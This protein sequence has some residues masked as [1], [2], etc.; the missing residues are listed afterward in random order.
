MKPKQLD[1]D[2]VEESSMNEVSSPGE[3]L[4]ILLEPE[5]LLDKVSSI[6]CPEKC[7]SSQDPHLL[8]R[9]EVLIRE[10]GPQNKYCKSHL[11]EA[12][13]SRRTLNAMSSD[14]E[15]PVVQR[16]L[17]TP[18]SI[19]LPV[20]QN[21]LS[22][23]QVSCDNLPGSLRKEV[24][25]SK[26]VSENITLEND[27]GS[28]KVLAD[29]FSAAVIGN[30]LQGNT[31]KTV[32]G[33]KV[34]SHPAALMD[35]FNVGLTNEVLCIGTLSESGELSRGKLTT[36]GK[37][38]SFPTEIQIME[39]FKESITSDVDGLCHQH[40]K[41]KT[42]SQPDKFLPPSSSSL[43]KPLESIKRSSQK[44]ILDGRDRSHETVL[45]FTSNELGGFPVLCL[46]DQG[47]SSPH[48]CLMEQK[49]VANPF[50]SGVDST[51]RGTI[52]N[53][54]HTSH[55][56]NISEHESSEHLDCVERST[57]RVRNDTR[58]NA[59]LLDDSSVPPGIYNSVLNG[60]DETVPEF[61]KFV[62]KSDDS[63]PSTAVDGIELE[64]FSL[65]SNTTEYPSILGDFRNSAFMNS[66]LCYS[67]TRYGLQKIPDL[68]Q[69]LPNGLLEG[70]DLRTSFSPNDERGRSLSDC[71]P[72]FR[73]QQSWDIKKPYASPVTLWDKITSNFGSSAK[74][75]SLKPELPCISEENENVDGMADTFQM[76]IGSE[77]IL[78]AIRRQPL[79]EITDNAKASAAVS[80][81]DILADGRG[82]ESIST[83]LSFSGTQIKAKKKL[84][85]QNGCKNRCTGTGKEIQSILR[86][87]NGPKRKTESSHNRS[88]RP[89]LSAKNSMQKRGPTYSGG[90]SIGN[91]IVSTIT[92][93]IPLVQQKQ[94]AAACTGK[95]DIKVKALETAVAAKRIA[96]KKENERKMKKEALRLERERLEQENLRQVEL[97]KKKKEEERKR[98][99]AEMAAKKR[100]R[101]E[102]ERKERERK[103]K[104][105]D[106]AKR[107]QK[108]H[109]E[110]KMCA[111]KE[112]RDMKSQAAVERA[113]ESKE[114]IDEREI[115]K[116]M[117][118]NMEGIRKN[119]QE[120][121]SMTVSNPTNDETK[122]SIIEDSE[123]VN[124]FENDRKVISN[125]T[126]AAQDDDLITKNT[127]E[128]QS[129]EI[130]PY[131]GSDDEDEDEDD[132]PSNKFI[133]SWASKHRL[134]RMVSSQQTV[135]PETVFPRQS[136]CSIAEVLLPR[137][138]QLN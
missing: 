137:R 29:A 112:E 101:E 42:E 76:E 45:T 75:E 23:S 62:V 91:N 130:S 69:S 66:P 113:Q 49:G 74:Q 27:D 90:M 136:F 58:G 78:S 32:T 103:R 107:K 55:H 2:D 61:E 109:E 108:E 7:N 77:L 8:E 9:Q 123:A 43:E 12:D 52:D 96:E 1:F 94:A 127:P 135:D 93:F 16:K 132:G 26:F 6:E 53:S 18:T 14:K 50:H 65:L 118:K 39:T 89:K 24:M 119:M 70:M 60:T 31:D 117:D 33:L 80:Q 59:K 82:V 122:A 47:S 21:H 100:V 36:D 48:S 44:F 30:G 124:D 95:R 37:D 22:P 128:V 3:G 126:K 72:N 87:P 114:F 84:E 64:K 99:E 34:G 54:L 104:R 97:Q 106:D 25:V 4:M 138:L 20:V 79:A 17:C 102:E 40:K 115:Q 41:R 35:E 73:G 13:E 111:K 10:E 67:P 46:N 63:K 51:R 11:T 83:E 71:L 38:T 28:I 121:K 110:K 19:E 92:S 105:I 57:S 56:Q 85:E 86:G 131:K 129:Y 88:G 120:A 15:L 116:N 134:S 133:P 98:K 81:D 125:M 5:N 68:F